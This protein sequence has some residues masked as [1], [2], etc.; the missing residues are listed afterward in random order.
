MIRYSGVLAVLYAFA[1]TQAFDFHRLLHSSSSKTVCKQAI[2]ALGACVLI[3]SAPLPSTADSSGFSGALADV[4]VGQYLVKDGRQLLRLSL[5][6]GKDMLMG[7]QARST[8]SQQA[9]EAAELV[10]LRIEETGF[11]NPAALPNAKLD[12]ERL[13]GLLTGPKGDSTF[14]DTAVSPE[15]ARNYR[16]TT[17]LPLIEK[18]NIAIK[19]KNIENIMKYQEE[20]AQALEN[21]RA[22]ELS[23]RSLPYSIPSEYDNLPRLMGRA[24][25]EMK[26]ESKHGGFKDENGKKIDS[27]K[28]VLEVDGYH[29]PLT[30]GNMVDLTMKK[31][32]DNMDI[33][34]VEELIV[35]TG[36]TVKDKDAGYIDPSNPK[37]VRTIPLEIFYKN[38]K[39]PVYGIT[40]DDDNRA[41]E[42]KALPFQA[43]GALGMAREEDPDSAS[44]QFFFLKW[45]QALVAP[46]RN[47]L[48]GYYS[49]M[50]YVVE[51]EQ[52][53][54]Q[55]QVGDKIVYG[56]VIEGQDNFLPKGNIKTA[57][58]LEKSN[59]IITAKVSKADFLKA[60]RDGAMIDTRDKKAMMEE[61]KSL[62]RKAGLGSNDNTMKREV[63]PVAPGSTSTE[64]R[65][66]LVD[67]LKVLQNMKANEKS[68]PVSSTTKPSPLIS[69][70]GIQNVNAAEIENIDETISVKVGPYDGVETPKKRYNKYGKIIEDKGYTD[71]PVKLVDM[72]G[73]RGARALTSTGA[74]GPSLA[75]QLK[76]YG[77]PGENKEKYVDN[78]LKNPLVYKDGIGD[79]LKLYQNLNK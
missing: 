17:L 35:Q 45:L 2:S 44:S 42:T 54:K 15:K 56:K 19:D 59:T 27:P 1:T 78:S 76:A 5:P 38:D 7:K 75:E 6:V 57:S 34:R 21:L 77:G 24:K 66:D 8:P 14:I 58:V 55:L 68:I 46:G 62:E 9:Q 13:V 28:I 3:G 52:I 79:Q 51:N 41:K 18:C 47:T 22:M 64:G 12:L 23:P 49:C 72:G 37:E 69:L 25:I 11:T 32:Y 4:G 61:T 10:R 65:T 16:D 33:Q 71:G 67:Q 48:D 39:E 29:A 73:N 36:S 43:Y 40:S 60:T 53:L 31:F 20:T 74:S 50:G 70:L 30:A 63:K 26:L